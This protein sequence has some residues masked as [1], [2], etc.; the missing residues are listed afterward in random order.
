MGQYSSFV[1]RATLTK[2]A[3]IIQNTT[4]IEGPS[5][6]TPLFVFDLNSFL[7]VTTDIVVPSL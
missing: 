4:D 7:N 2:V 5:V 3:N 6:N 1:R